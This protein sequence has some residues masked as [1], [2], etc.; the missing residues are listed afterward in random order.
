[1]LAGV[2][3]TYQYLSAQPAGAQVAAN[4]AATPTDIAK[5]D[6][7]AEQASKKPAAN[8][9]LATTTQFSE[10][11]ALALAGGKSS[12]VRD[13]LKFSMGAVRGLY[14]AGDSETKVAAAE[15]GTPAKRKGKVPQLVFGGS[16]IDGSQT[17]AV[18]GDSD[19]TKAAAASDG[20]DD[21]T[22]EPAAPVKWAAADKGEAQDLGDVHVTITKVTQG[23]VAIA[24]KDIGVDLTG[25]SYLTVWLK[26]ENKAGVGDVAYTSWMDPEGAKSALKSEVV[27]E[28]GRP[29]KICPLLKGEY[30]SGTRPTPSIGSNSSITDALAYALPKDEVK[31]LRLMLP[32]QAVGQ[33]GNLY[34]EIPWSMVK[35]EETNPL[36]GGLGNQ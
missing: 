19:S 36:I 26:I 30:I 16:G 13:P 6:A 17:L 8:P 9:A 15:S 11:A 2:Y 7:T 34:F 14:A 33:K 32:G 29:Y 35:A 10:G 12:D 21:K 23:R 4:A 3:F 5:Q 1:M 24:G 20:S 25:E 22:A 31:T 28:Q 27:D 18:A